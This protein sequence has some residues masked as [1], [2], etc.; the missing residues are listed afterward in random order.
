M[1][2]TLLDI[3]DLHVT[4]NTP[5]GPVR[6]VR[7]VSLEI[8]QGEILGVVGESGCGKSVTFRAMLGLAPNSATVDGRALLR[9]EP[10]A[11]D[12]ALLDQTSLIYQNPGA[13]LNPVFTI[14]QQL[15]LALSPAG[16]G[17]PRTRFMDAADDDQEMIALLDRVGLPDPE[18]SLDAY[19]HE[20][21]GGMKQRALIALALAKQPELLIADEPTTALDVTTQAQVL[22]LLRDLRDQDD[23]TIVFISHDLAVIKQLCDRV[24]VLYAGQLV[25]IGTVDEVLHRPQHP[26][27]AAL[28]NSIPSQEHLGHDLMTIPGLVPDGRHII[29]GCG[30]ADRCPHVQAICTSER[31]AL[32]TLSE[33]HQA[34]CVLVEGAT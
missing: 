23:L 18:R 8:Q 13:A 22:E 33:G 4:F 3:D 15:R 34:A 20:F 26:Y 28:L 14:G 1:S 21:S 24:A 16:P 19:P 2:P 7:G 32:A 10:V 17:S 30:F 29:P 31:P 11:L 5:S 9:E 27:T 6:A 12:G 25:E